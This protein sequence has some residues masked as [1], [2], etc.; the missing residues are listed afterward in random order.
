MKLYK[1]LLLKV[2]II[3]EGIYQNITKYELIKQSKKKKV[4]KMEITD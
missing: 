1:N 4:N 2:K 3:K